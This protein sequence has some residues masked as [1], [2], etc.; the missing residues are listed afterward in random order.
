MV[1]ALRPPRRELFLATITKVL[2]Y[3]V[4]NKWW[5]VP[6]GLYLEPAAR[7]SNTLLARYT[8]T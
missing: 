6:G 1:K 8:S 5:L 7:S 4:V 3:L 2:V